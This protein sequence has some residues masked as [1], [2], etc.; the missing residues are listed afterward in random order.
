MHLTNDLKN[1]IDELVEN[2]E[3]VVEALKGADHFYICHYC[4]K[5]EQIE[6]RRCYWDDKSTRNTQLLATELSQIYL[7]SQGELQSSQLARR[8]NEYRQILQELR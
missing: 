6:H 8:Y 3:E 7:I 1:G 4:K 2:Q 5:R